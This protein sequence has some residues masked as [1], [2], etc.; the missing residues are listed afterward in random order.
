MLLYELL[1]GFLC[2]GIQS[3]QLDAA[4]Q[5]TIVNGTDLYRNLLVRKFADGPS[6]SGHTLNQNNNSL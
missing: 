3:G 6:V 2:K 1:D 4:I 5:K